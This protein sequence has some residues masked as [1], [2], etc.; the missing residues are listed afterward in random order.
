MNTFLSENVFCF[1]ILKLNYIL[2]LAVM[3]SF[4]SAF[5]CSFSEQ[6]QTQLRPDEL[7]QHVQ[8]SWFVLSVWD[9][10]KPASALKHEKTQNEI[11]MNAGLFGV[12]GCS[13]WFKKLTEM[14]KAFTSQ[15][16]LYIEWSKCGLQAGK[17]TFALIVSVKHRNTWTLK[18]SRAR[19]PWNTVQKPALTH[20][21]AANVCVCLNVSDSH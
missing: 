12:Q 21:T 8:N 7:G 6:L 20:L 1:P 4:H 9:V 15:A 14:L 19:L 2:P 10:L 11:S 18:V 17:R 16:L 3:A 5:E 13:C